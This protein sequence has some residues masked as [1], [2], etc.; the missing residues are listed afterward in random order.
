MD[1]VPA[2]SDW[3][4]PP[5]AQD[6]LWVR[7]G[8]RAVKTSGPRGAFAL[9]AEP[10]ALRLAWG[11]ADG[12]PLCL[13]HHSPYVWQGTVGVGGFIERLHAFEAH[14]LE[15]VVAEIEGGLLPTNYCRLPTCAQ[16]QRAPFRRDPETEQP[17]PESFIYLFLALA[18]SVQA[19]YLHH[20]MVGQLAV[21]CFAT[22]G[23]QQGGWHELVGLPLL[24]DSVSL[25]ASRYG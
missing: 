25:L 10:A 18:D 23:P 8:D 2:E 14:G 9:D 22:L 4:I 15:L 24:L 7:G 1:L 16:M 19:E 12:P 20:A 5:Y 3:R 11:T 17:L 21:D 6:M 13:W